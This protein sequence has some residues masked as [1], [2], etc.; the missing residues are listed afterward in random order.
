M[1]IDFGQQRPDGL[2]VGGDQRVISGGENADPFLFRQGENAAGRF[3]GD[4]IGPDWETPIEETIEALS[5]LM[6]EGKI[7]AIGLS[8][9]YGWQVSMANEK[10][11]ALGKPLF[12]A[13]QNQ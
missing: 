7:K 11:A 3:P 8:N 2:A 13:V 10:A 1:Y 4:G 6:E 9:V 12:A 5:E